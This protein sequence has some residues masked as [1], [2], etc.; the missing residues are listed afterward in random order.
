MAMLNDGTKKRML[1]LVL[2]LGLT[3]LAAPGAADMLVLIPGYLADG[4]DW[5]ESGV[6]DS[7]R[8]AGWTDG[9]NLT[10]YWGRPVLNGGGPTGP[11]RFYTLDLDSQAP[12]LY[13]EQQLGAY[14]GM[15]SGQAEHERL[16]LAGHSAGGVLARLYMVRHPDSSV[17]AL[18]TIASP[19]LGTETAE[20]GLQA[21][22]SPLRWLTGILGADTLNR[23]QGLYF[24]LARER[25]GSLLFWLNR[26]R[27]PDARYV[28]VVRTGEDTLFGD[29][30]VPEWSQDMNRVPAL[31]GRALRVDAAGGHGL[32]ADD[33]ALLARIL[34]RLPAF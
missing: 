28:A 18:I 1:G 31:S 23:S 30:V 34:A 7:L 17:R 11:M 9:G 8:R 14:L 13:Q 15:L 24:D 2:V 12:L 27:H 29:L 16:I 21:G 25:P 6:T 10:L 5:R 26:Q 3:A 22:Q 32:N 19:H 33:G 4:R 20:L